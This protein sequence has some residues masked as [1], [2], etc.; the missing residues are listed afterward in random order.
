MRRLTLTLFALALAAG[1]AVAPRHLVSHTATSPDFVHFESG[2]VRPACLTPAGNRLLVVNTS[3]NRLAVFDLST[4]PPSRDTR[5]AEIPVGLEPVSVAAR[6]DSEAWVVNQLSDDVSIVNL[7]TLHVRATIRVGDEPA[8]V[9]FAGS[10]AVAY[11][12]VMDEDAVKAFDPATLA[13]VATIPIPGRMPRSLAATADGSKIYV[14]IFGAGN[15][16]TTMSAARVPDDSIPQDPSFPKDT[17]NGPAPKTGLIVQYQAV[18]GTPQGPG[19]YDTYGNFWSSKIKYQP[20]DVDVAEIDTG[21]NSVSR[22][23]GGAASLFNHIAS[24]NFA[25]AVRPTDGRVFDVNTNAR[26]LLRFEPA[27]TGYLVETQISWI[28]QAGTVTNRKLDP[29]INYNVFPGTQAEADSAIGTPTGVA[30][31]G[32][33]SVV[34]VTSLATSKIAVVNPA[35]GPQSTVRA[36]IPCVPGPTGV[37]VDDARGLIYIVGRFGNQVQTLSTTDFTQRSI[38]SLGFDPTPDDIVNGRRDFYGGFG[39]AHGDQSCASCHIFGDADGVAWDLGDPQGADAPPPSGQQ[40]TL[41]QGYHPMKGPMMTQSLRGMPGTGVL[42]WRGDRA[43]V[44]AFNPAFVSLMGRA[45]QLPDSQMIAISTFANALVYP[46]NPNEALDR[47]FPDAPIG[48]PS[49]ARGQTFFMNTPVQGTLRCV[50][51]HAAANFAPGTNAQVID[52]AAIQQTQDFKVPQLRNLYKQRGYR[53]SVGAVNQRG[54]GLL[55]DGTVDN[56][57][58]FLQSPRFSFPGGDADRAD[59][60]A[61]LLA[62]DTGMA[63]AVGYQLTFDGT[64]G[65]DAV[66]QARMDTLEGQADAGNCELIAKGRVNGQPRGW[67]YTGG[68]NWK[69]DKAAEA[70][71]TRGALLAFAGP[72]SEVTVTGVPVGSGQRMGLDRDR[73]GYLDGDE[74]DAHSDPGDPASTPLNVGVAP[75]GAAVEGVRRVA[76]NPFTAG[77]EIEFAIGRGG[78]VTLRVYDLLGREVREVAHGAALGAGDHHLRWDGRNARGQAAGPGV[79]FLRLETPVGAWTRPVVKLR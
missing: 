67:L 54:F 16:T 11:V 60:A 49:A 9:I 41:L 38:T 37:V 19:W 46:P 53:D 64:N 43:N 73:D 50:D 7:N 14:G 51:C 13:Q 25:L 17:L 18:D 4:A 57:M 31:A 66:A 34:Y 33:G 62:F 78:P 3:D 36:R 20:S 26:S 63:P 65:G 45:A 39:S 42:H 70:A 30:C 40:D 12:S 22:T 8:D 28:T 2:H 44:R 55:H 59:V 52:H 77:T 72:G 24:D 61:F 58:D 10:P 75:R 56:L 71:L 1:L 69:S 48:Q 47:T 32:D 15:M 27:V 29:Q 74:L 35:G 5:I 79:Y 76:P 68:G 6:S 23:F 21:S